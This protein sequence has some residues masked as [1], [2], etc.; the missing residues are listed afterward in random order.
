[1]WWLALGE[2]TK[3]WIGAAWARRCLGHALTNDQRVRL[4]LW[5]TLPVTGTALLSL[6]FSLSRG[7]WAAGL[8]HD[9]WASIAFGSGHASR[10]PLAALGVVGCAMLLRYLLLTL[11]GARR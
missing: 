9:G 11:F 8:V 1:L 5:Y 10:L 4:A 3:A 7:G 2:L 6:P